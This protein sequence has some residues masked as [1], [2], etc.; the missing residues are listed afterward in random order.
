VS[1]LKIPSGLFVREDIHLLWIYA[2]NSH[3]RAFCFCVCFYK[4]TVFL[5]PAAVS[6][7]SQLR[8]WKISD[9]FLILC[10]TACKKRPDQG[11]LLATDIPNLV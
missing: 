8:A 4:E 10:V 1:V 5:F 3:F 6:S 11:C 2:R 7:D 9:S